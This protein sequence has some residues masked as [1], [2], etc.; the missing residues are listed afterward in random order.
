MMQFASP[1]PTLNDV[2]NIDTYKMCS[3]CRA[4]AR[5]ATLAKARYGI[6]CNW[7]APNILGVKKIMACREEGI[8][9]TFEINISLGGSGL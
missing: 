5:G 2:L 3:A 8:T 6:F 4:I 9:L 1:P 7:L